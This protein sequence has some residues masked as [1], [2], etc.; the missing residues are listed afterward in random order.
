MKELV[1]RLFRAVPSG[2]GS[3][4]QDLRL[5][6]GQMRQVLE[7]GASWAI[8][9]GYGS[10]ADRDSIEAGGRIAGANV[11]GVSE[12][13]MQ[14]GR[15]QLGTLGSGNHFVEIGYVEEIF[16]AAAARALRLEQ[17]SVTVIIHTGSRGLG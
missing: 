5:E 6:P 13:A 16:D 10:S 3:H 4:R 2:V 12:R 15:N 9:Q 7:Q 11:E 17:D 1:D 8:A 14:R